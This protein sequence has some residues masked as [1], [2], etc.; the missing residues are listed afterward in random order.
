MHF[1]KLKHLA[2]IAALLPLLYACPKKK[3]ALAPEADTELQ[4]SI[5]AVF[6]TFLVTDIEMV[7]AHI[8]QNDYYPAFYI[9]QPVEDQTKYIAF[10]T[11]VRYV[12][13]FNNVRCMDGR[14]RKGSIV[15]DYT[16]TNPN[17]INYD[18][19]QFHGKM[20]LSEYFVDEWLIKTV[21]GVPCDITNELVSPIFD[22]K[23]TNLVWTIKGSFEFIN[24]TDP[25]KNM[26]WSG[27]LT[28][29]LE[30]TNESAVYSA[31]RLIPIDWT[32]AKVKYTGKATGM[33]SGNVPF[34]LNINPYFPVTR[35]F[36]CYPN[37][38]GGIQSASPLVTWKNESHPFIS[39][40]LSFKT[41]GKYPREIYLGN[42][43][44]PESEAQ[45][46]NSG[47]VLIKGN[48]YAVNFK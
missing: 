43:G 28:K 36:T 37:E 9:P 35:E 31:N 4:S 39:G 34:E 5:D 27:E 11:S 13:T 24:S 2:L 23:K 25:S 14:L 22:P 42:E 10:N 15:M 17:A 41:N 26:L 3:T 29:T 30:N 16:N 6:A 33:T 45:C 47:L 8:G 38:I 7:C 21:D 18:K 44:I 19:Y 32:K 46:D 20:T 48:S 12:A 1:S 40:E